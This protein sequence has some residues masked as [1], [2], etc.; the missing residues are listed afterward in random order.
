LK[1]DIHT[2]HEFR[3]DLYREGEERADLL[4]RIK[5]RLAEAFPGMKT[6]MR[7]GGDWSHSSLTVSILGYPTADLS[8]REEGFSARR[9]IDAEL[10]RFTRHDWEPNHGPR[11]VS[12]YTNTQIDPAL[13]AAALRDAPSLQSRLSFAE[14]TRQARPG[15]V[16]EHIAGV[17]PHQ[18]ARVEIVAIS[19]RRLTTRAA[20]GSEEGKPQRNPIQGGACF[21][22]DGETVCFRHSGFASVGGYSHMRWLRV[23]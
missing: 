16:L 22:S 13:H 17:V 19:S 11:N 4:K 2:A 8:V 20:Q 5:A 6:A 9:L 12:L 1:T 3:G 14:F 7:W 15:D 10:Q 18:G 21:V 23:A